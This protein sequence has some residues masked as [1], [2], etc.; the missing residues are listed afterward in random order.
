MLLHSHFGLMA[1]PPERQERSLSSQAQVRT[2][3]SNK[4]SFLE[5][6][7]GWTSRRAAKTATQRPSC[8]ASE[9][10]SRPR[11]PGHDSMMLPPEAPQMSLPC[12]APRPTTPAAPPTPPPSFR[13]EARTQSPLQEAGAMET[14][15]GRLSQLSLERAQEKQAQTQSSEKKSSPRRLVR[16]YRCLKCQRRFRTLENATQ[17]FWCEDPG[18]LQERLDAIHKEVA[19]EAQANRRRHNSQDSQPARVVRQRTG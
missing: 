16:R 15:R 18:V 14:I 10:P 3:N 8:C 17:H 4:T 7:M 5:R 12:L 11:A 9:H 6:L 13:A 2:H 1:A 19:A